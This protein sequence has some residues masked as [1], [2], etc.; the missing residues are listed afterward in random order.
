M[1]EYMQTDAFDRF[2]VDNL[3]LFLLLFAD[4]TVLFSCSQEGLQLLLN[5]LND[6]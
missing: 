3:K 1:Y 4:D 2:T 5:K 6:Y